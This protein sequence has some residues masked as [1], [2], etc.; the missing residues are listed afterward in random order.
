MASAVTRLL[1]VIHSCVILEKE[2]ASSSRISRTKSS[3]E[4][5]SAENRKCQKEHRLMPFGVYNIFITDHCNTG[6]QLSLK[7]S[8]PKAA[9][10]VSRLE[11]PYACNMGL[12]SMSTA[13]QC[14]F[15]S[16]TPMNF[17]M[18]LDWGMVCKRLVCY[19]CWIVSVQ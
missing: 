8:E 1:N 7:F 15:F 12:D 17:L 18:A 16:A 2:I 3:V 10:L 13:Q 11:L 5:A 19:H 9:F 4:H 6:A 14:D